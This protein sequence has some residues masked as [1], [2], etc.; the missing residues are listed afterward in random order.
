M[1]SGDEKD[2]D[3]L[4]E[5]VEITKDRSNSGVRSMEQ[6][7]EA[8]NLFKKYDQLRVWKATYKGKTLNAIAVILTENTVWNRDSGSLRGYNKLSA[9]TYLRWKIAE[10]YAKEGKRDTYNLMGVTPKAYRDANRPHTLDGVTKFK[11]IFNPEISDSLGVFELPLDRKLYKRFK[12]VEP[13]IVRFYF[14][15]KKEY[16]Y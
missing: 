15:I 7:R 13:W 6:M 11:Q 5:L 1:S 12:I 2:I 14:R 8:W 16:W 3:D 4:A 9:T 10:F